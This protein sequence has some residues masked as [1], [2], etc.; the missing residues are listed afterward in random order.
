MYNNFP[1]PQASQLSSNI[2][3]WK[4]EGLKQWEPFRMTKPHHFFFCWVHRLLYSLLSFLLVTR[5][6]LCHTQ[7]RG[8]RWAPT[9][10]W[11]KDSTAIRCTLP[12][13]WR[14]SAM[15]LPGGCRSSPGLQMERA[16]LQRGQR[17][18][19][20]MPTQ[21]EGKPI[22]L[23]PLWNLLNAQWNLGGKGCHLSCCTLLLTGSST[24]QFVPNSI[25]WW[26]LS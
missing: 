2:A 18:D 26:N 11:E 9:P 6:P 8:S 13:A 25:K 1:T 16:L 21:R 3:S 10:P 20:Q 15:G 5:T 23:N 24:M 19:S 7:E 14:V 17:A 22:P 4:W 12:A